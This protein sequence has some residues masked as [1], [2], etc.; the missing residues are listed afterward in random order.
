MYRKISTGLI[1]FVFF[2]TSATV[3]AQEGI[4]VVP[5][6]DTIKPEAGSGT[7]K[8]KRRRRVAKVK[9]GETFLVELQTALSSGLT[10]EG[11]VVYLKAAGDVGP[12]RRPAIAAGAPGRGTVIL[13]DKKGRKVTVRLQ[14][15]DNPRGEPVAITGTIDV[16]GDKRTA[17]NASVGEKFTASLTEDVIP[18]RPIKKRKKRGKKGSEPQVLTAF[19]EISGKGAK[20]DLKKGK[21]KGKVKMILEAPSGYTSDDV[22]LGS[23]ELYEINGY[24]LSRGIPANA[25]KPKQ[26]DAN[27][28]GTSDWTIYFN[29]WDFIKNQPEGNNL[30][31]VRGRL[32]NGKDFDAVTRVKVDY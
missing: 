1:L 30:V 18:K 13:V 2:F 22:E 31:H 10:Q 7:P 27:K 9:A 26:G 17:A 15:L 5:I 3:L 4:K 19:I 20:A 14:T 6:G 8:K 32:K 25:G 28:N 24:K 16:E 23:V 21:A 12:S 11:D 29:T